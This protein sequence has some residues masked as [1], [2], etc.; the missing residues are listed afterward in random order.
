MCRINTYYNS[1]LFLD[2]QFLISILRSSKFSLQRTKEK[3]DYYCTIK[4]LLPEFF[5]HRD[6]FNEDIQAVLNAG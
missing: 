3:L 1:I 5:A 2:N 6:P 4:T